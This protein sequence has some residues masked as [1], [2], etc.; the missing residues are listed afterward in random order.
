MKFDLDRDRKRSRQKK[1]IL[2]IA[3]WI[4]EIAAVIGLAYFIINFALEKT[5]MLGE[6]MHITLEKDDKIIIN[7]LAYKFGKPKRFDVVVFKQS[8][9]EHSYYNIK[10]VIGLPG[11]T[12]QIKE[13]Y[14]YI[15][16]EL[17]KEPMITDPILIGGLADDKITLEENE[18]FV[19][20]DNRNNSEDSRFANIAN[21]VFD[22]IIGKAWLRLSPFDFVNKINMYE[23][24]VE[25]E[26]IIETE[27]KDEVVTKAENG[28]KAEV[29]MN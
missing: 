9:D 7:K 11:E 27:T 22:D 13:G 18:Y 20:G 1:L 26:E 19:L 6:S 4:I 3:L 8:G 28:T 12:V 24:A 14:V 17:L 29:E 15:N 10:R 5:T 23:K 21:V 25:E 16:D 2:R